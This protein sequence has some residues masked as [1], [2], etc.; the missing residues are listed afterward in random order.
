VKNKIIYHYHGDTKAVLFFTL[1]SQGL[2]AALGTQRRRGEREF[3]V[4]E[5]SYR[6]HA[7]GVLVFALGSQWALRLVRTQLRRG[8]RVLCY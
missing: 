1:G 8:E 7:R 4:T 5:V 6:Y 2:C 3:Y